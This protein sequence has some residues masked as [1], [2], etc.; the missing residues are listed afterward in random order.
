MHHDIHHRIT[1]QNERYKAAAD[2]GHRSVSFCEGDLVMVR[3]RSEKYSPRVATKLHARSAAP[4]PVACVISENAY[5]VGIPP[6]WG[7]SS[8][9][10][11]SNL[12]R[13]RPLPEIF[14]PNTP[15]DLSSKVNER[16]LSA[17]PSLSPPRHE[18]VESVLSELINAAGDKVDRRFL[19]H[20][21]G[22][23]TFDDSWISE[24]ALHRLRPELI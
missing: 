1:S 14:M 12:A 11:V 19:V 2:V 7:I 24:D 15:S 5:V 4:F 3:L 9:F 20:W 17:P 6:N 8:T 13:C 10:N 23:P 21:Q 16:P 22:R 18:Y